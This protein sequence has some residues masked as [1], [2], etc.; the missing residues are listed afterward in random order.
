M[1]GK[2]VEETFRALFALT[3]LRQILRET[4]PTY[5]L[6][7]RQEERVRKILEAVGE[8]LA[9]I[10]KELLGDVRHREHR[11]QG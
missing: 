3:D 9:I 4:K 2:V 11:N 5:E 7:E 6:D 1:K 8:S 10:E